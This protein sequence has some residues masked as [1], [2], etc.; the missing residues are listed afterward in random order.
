SSVRVTDDI[1]T[2]SIK[3]LF[4]PHTTKKPFGSNANKW[5]RYLLT[6]VAFNCG[7]KTFKLKALTVYYEDETH[8]SVPAERIADDWEPIVPGN[9]LDGEL[10]FVCAWKSR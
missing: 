2:A 5:E 6:R 1:R 3:T 9:L 7:N 10:Q 8:E 4:A